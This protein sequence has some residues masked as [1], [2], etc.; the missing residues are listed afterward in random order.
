[1]GRDELAAFIPLAL[2]AVIF[3]AGCLIDIVRRP[4]VRYM[5]KWAW[6]LV[7]VGSIP[8]GGLVYLLV[9]REQS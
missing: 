6:A 9:G 4:K 7:C 3:V 5:P 8:L 2:V 1:M